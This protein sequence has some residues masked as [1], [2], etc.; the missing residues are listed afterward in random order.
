MSRLIIG[1]AAPTVTLLT[2]EGEPLELATL[3]PK[4]PL[5]LSFLRHFG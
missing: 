2:I 4:Q 3:W 5:L 1:D